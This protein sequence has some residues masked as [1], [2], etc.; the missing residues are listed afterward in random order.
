M[1]A[2]AAITASGTCRPSRVIAEA[3]AASSRSRLA[4]ASLRGRR[5]GRPPAAPPGLGAGVLVTFPH[6]PDRGPAAIAMV[7]Q[8]TLKRTKKSALDDRG[9]R[10]PSQPAPVPP[11]DPAREL[12]V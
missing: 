6:I 10:M 9:D 2:S 1:P 11:D 4:S 12:T 3:A 7:R 5:G 8:A